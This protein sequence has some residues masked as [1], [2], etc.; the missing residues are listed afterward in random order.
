MELFDG[1]KPNVSF[2]NDFEHAKE[3]A[4]E[5]AK[6]GKFK[7]DFDKFFKDKE[8]FKF[9]FDMDDWQRGIED[10]KFKLE[11]LNIDAPNIKI[12]PMPKLL[13]APTV[14]VK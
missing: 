2:N 13:K 12:A 10:M 1:V 8:K 11:E 5:F 9:D 4:K 14:I 6:E 3:F 7:G